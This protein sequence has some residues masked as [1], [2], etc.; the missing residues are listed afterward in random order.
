MRIVLMSVKLSITRKVLMT[1]CRMG[2]SMLVR[3]QAG[4][5]EN[6][7]PALLAMFPEEKITA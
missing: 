3:G 7:M 1:D 5:S 2:R 6:N 4:C